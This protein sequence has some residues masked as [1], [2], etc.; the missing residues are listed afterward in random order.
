MIYIYGAANSG[1]SK[2]AENM[3]LELEKKYDENL[4][5]VYLAC[6]KIYDDEDKKRVEKHR[7]QRKTKGFRTIEAYENLAKS[8]IK[9]NSLVLLECMSNYVAN[10]KFRDDFKVIENEILL[11]KL[12]K[13]LVLL[14]RS[15]RELVIVGNDIYNNKEDKKNE[16]SKETLD[17]I[18]LMYALHIKLKNYSKKVHEVVFSFVI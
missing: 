16:F 18:S 9:P 5:K 6:M 12:W 7:L 2:L 17:Y 4:D 8:D 14:D 13:D 1:K 11:K 10:N 3:I 15:C